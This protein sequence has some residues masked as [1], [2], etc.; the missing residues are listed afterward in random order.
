MLAGDL[1]DLVRDVAHGINVEQGADALYYA[2][3]TLEAHA[4]IDVLL[5]QLGVV[6]VA[7]VVELGEYVVPDLHVAVAVAADGAAR[8]AAAELG[9]AVV[10]D[11]R[12]RTARTGAM[13]PEVVL[14]AEAEDALGRDADLLVPDF[15]RLVVV[16]VDGRVQAVRVDADP[17]RARQELPAPVDRFALEVI[18][19]GEVAEHL[20][21]GAVARGLADVFDVAGA[22]ALLA[23]G[24]AAARRLLLAGEIR[25]HRRHAGVD[26][27]KRRVVL[28][29][30][31]KARQA[32]MTLGLEETEVHLAQLI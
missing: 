14:L 21:E 4:G 6:A 20:E 23:G 12:A 24:D 11:L 13:L 32:K 2:R 30:E 8:L 28:R 26:E 29:D 19:E 16:N 31:R 9:A 15:E 3:Q 1:G 27:Q 17:V 22:D 7:V 25:L 10:V 5:L 18:A